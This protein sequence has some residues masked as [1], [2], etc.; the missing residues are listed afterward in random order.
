MKYNSARIRFQT[1]Q[2]LS[3]WLRLPVLLAFLFATTLMAAKLSD[4]LQRVPPSAMVDVIVQF[5]GAPTAD[6]LQAIGR[7]GGA[8]KRHLPNINGALFTLP[9]AA[10][11]GISRNPHVLYLSPDRR[12]SGS[13]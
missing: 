5:T 12:L 1:S 6:D 10:L 7:S 13:L 11:Q 2:R 3:V 4:D 9:G 8:L